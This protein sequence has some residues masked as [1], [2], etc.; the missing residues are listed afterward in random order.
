MPV[1]APVVE[2][3]LLFATPVTVEQPEP[4]AVTAPVEVI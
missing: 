1:K 3:H 2:A 4:V